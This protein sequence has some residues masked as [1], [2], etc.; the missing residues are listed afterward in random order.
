[1]LLLML[2]SWTKS[3]P[4]T[5]KKKKDKINVMKFGDQWSTGIVRSLVEMNKIRPE[6]Q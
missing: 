4:S 2:V 1:M 6:V 3:W 5:M